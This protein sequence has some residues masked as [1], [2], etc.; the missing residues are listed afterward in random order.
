MYYRL[1]LNDNI[2]SSE[3]QFVTLYC[4]HVIY[5]PVLGMNYAG[6]TVFCYHCRN[7]KLNLTSNQVRDMDRKQLEIN[8]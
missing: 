3:H 4:G 7:M 6:K 2:Y 1:C 8:S 5:A